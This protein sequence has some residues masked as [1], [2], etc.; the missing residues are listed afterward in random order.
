MKLIIEKNIPFI[1]GLL[2]GM[3]DVEYLAPED[4]T[5]ETMRDADALITRTRTRCDAALLE[6][7]RCRL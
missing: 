7:S 1:Q 6:G 4:I 3:A 5:T 2:D